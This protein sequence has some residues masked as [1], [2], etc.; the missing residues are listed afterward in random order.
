MASPEEIRALR[1]LKAQLEPR[2]KLLQVAG[3]AR[4]EARPYFRATWSQPHRA[5]RLCFFSSST[6]SV[7]SNRLKSVKADDSYPEKST[8]RS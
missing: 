7:L 8:F 3:E 4:G 5:S 1:L 6:R 2:W